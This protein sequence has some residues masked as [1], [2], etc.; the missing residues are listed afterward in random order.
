MSWGGGWDDDV[1]PE[2]VGPGA[3]PGG[4]WDGGDGAQEEEYDGEA[5]VQPEG[6]WDR[7]LPS[8]QGEEK[9]K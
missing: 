9:T 2:G 1:R 3:A 5:A 6:L 8:A 4:L 7:V